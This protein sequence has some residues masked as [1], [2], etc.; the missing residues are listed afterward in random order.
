[1]IDRGTSDVLSD[2][3]RDK[4]H[5]AVRQ[6]RHAMYALYAGAW[7]LSMVLGGM[8]VFFFASPDTFFVVT[9]SLAPLMVV[10]GW[11]LRNEHRSRY[12]YLPGL[13]LLTGI[14]FFGAV[15]YHQPVIAMFMLLPAIFMAVLYRY[16]RWLTV[17]N[18]VV[19]TALTFVAPVLA[20]VA[21]PL[22]VSL[23]MTPTFA[24]LVVA[25]GHLGAHASRL[26]IERE[27][28]DSTISSLLVA[29]RERD[30]ESAEGAS[31]VE[32]LAALVAESM[33]VTGD[34]LSL[35]VDSARLHDVGKIGIPSELLDKPASLT[36][37]EWI[38][39]RT[40]PEI[41]ERIVATVPGF[42]DVAI[43]VRHTH[44]RWDGNGYPDRL[45]GDEIPLASR[46]IFA[47]DAYE[48]MTS[49][50]PF[51]PAHAHEEA[52]RELRRGA[53]TQFDPRVVSALLDVLGSRR[54]LDFGPGGVVVPL[55]RIAAA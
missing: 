21:E 54:G 7:L 10:A 32:G 36:S 11:P 44:E 15:H 47:C 12:L 22:R 46:I 35:V 28:F 5:D 52:C 29:L 25:L 13:W 51:R 14:T 55:H 31:R 30:G 4:N 43:V 50:R 33:G 39:M 49:T 23:M 20:D 53:G 17:F 19:V 37:D 41:G 26:N 42:D 38:V 48:A 1:M 27:R 24:T 3:L 9:M 8:F 40:H 6:E 45:A 34:E 18:L 16:D 2:S